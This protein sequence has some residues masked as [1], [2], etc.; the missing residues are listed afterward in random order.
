MGANLDIDVPYQFLQFFLEDDEEYKTI[1]EKYGKGEMLTGE[2]KQICIKALQDF[3]ADYQER[4]AK[5]TDEDVKK[6]ME[7][8]RIDP[9]SEKCTK[10]EKPKK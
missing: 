6:F 10:E 9:T 5:V 8:R 3:V 4:R 1:G 7:I 2:V